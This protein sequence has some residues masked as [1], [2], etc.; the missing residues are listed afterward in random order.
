MKLQLFTQQNLS[1]IFLSP[2]V[3][4]FPAGNDTT[5]YSE[6]FDTNIVLPGNKTEWET[7][8]GEWEQSGIEYD[9]LLSALRTKIPEK[10]ESLI[11]QMLI[12]GILE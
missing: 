1:R 3:Y 10:T 2:Y 7:F 8:F 5:L 12:K 9:N 6:L 11:R 4:F